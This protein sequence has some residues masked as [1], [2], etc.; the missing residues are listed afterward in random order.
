MRT[1]KTQKSAFTLIELLTVVAI[2]AIL[3]ALLFPAI[4]T[5]IKKAEKARAQ[6]AVTGLAV[7]FKAYFNEFSRFPTNFPS[8]STSYPITTNSFDPPPGRAKISVFDFTLDKKNRFVDPWGNS[9]M[10]RVDA[11]YDNQV[12]PP[13]GAV[14]N[15]SVLVWSWGPSG[16]SSTW[17]GDEIQ[18]W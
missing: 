12:T 16:G 9:Y 10:V 13:S 2:I 7:G 14:V 4:G 6:A 3:V 15:A 17:S 5:A 1:H 11:N 18:S 8:D